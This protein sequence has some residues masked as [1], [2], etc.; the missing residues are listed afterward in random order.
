MLSIMKGMAEIW[1]MHALAYTLHMQGKKELFFPSRCEF[2]AFHALLL[3]G[4]TEINESGESRVREGFR[5]LPLTCLGMERRCP[6][7]M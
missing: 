7:I 6:K 4:F 1:D 2:L 5:Y 3:R